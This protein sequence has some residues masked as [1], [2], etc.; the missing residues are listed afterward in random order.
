MRF[1]KGLLWFLLF[2]GGIVVILSL[3]ISIFLSAKQ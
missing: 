3:M 1:F 2:L